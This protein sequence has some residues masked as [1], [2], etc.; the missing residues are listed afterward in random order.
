M[1]ITRSQFNFTNPSIVV[2]IIAYACHATRD[3]IIVF[4]GGCIIIGDDYD[5]MNMFCM[6]LRLNIYVS[7]SQVYG[8]DASHHLSCTM[9]PLKPPIH[10]HPMYQNSGVCICM[11]HIVACP[12]GAWDWHALL[13][14]YYHKVAHACSIMK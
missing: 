10:T 3:N 9:Y 14:R 12:L 7:S 5:D 6:V 13:E 4:L 11:W 2:I 8:D 1:R